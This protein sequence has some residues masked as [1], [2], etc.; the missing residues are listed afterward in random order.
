MNEHIPSES[1]LR[2]IFACYEDVLRRIRCSIAD[3]KIVVSIDV[4]GRY[5]PNV[6]FAEC[7]EKVFLLVSEV[8]SRENHLVI[9]VLLGNAM[10]LLW[11]EEVR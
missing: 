5:V 2:K 6:V 11:P 10:E 4:D 1:A 7:P 9:A 8:L 3:N